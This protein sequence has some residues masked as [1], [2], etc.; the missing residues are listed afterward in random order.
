MMTALISAGVAIV[1]CS[2]YYVGVP[3]IWDGKTIGKKLMKLQICRA[4]GRKLDF[5]T[6]FKREI[7]GVMLLEGGVAAS[8]GYLREM[9]QL[10][11]RGNVLLPLSIASSVV[12]I[13]S[14]FIAVVGKEKRMLHDY[15]GG[16]VVRTA[17]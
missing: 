16:T 8:S 13:G 5:Y 14:V 2:L 11:V 10:C 7:I 9:L 17:V 6:L 3:L 4:D 1:F 12:T 15:V